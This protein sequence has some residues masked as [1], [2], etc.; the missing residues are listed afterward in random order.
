[1]NQ[2]D[3]T[4][5]PNIF[6]GLVA[7]AGT[8]LEPVKNQIKGQFAVAGYDYD[9]I[10]VSKLMSHFANVDTMGLNQYTR[11][12][13]LMNLGDKIRRTAADGSAVIWLVL[14]ELNEKLTNPRTNNP[15]VFVI[16]S[17][18]NPAEIQ[19]LDNVFSRNYYT[20]GVYSPTNDR[21]ERLANLIAASLNEKVRSEHF[22]QAEEI[23]VNDEGRKPEKL[24]QN[25]LNTFPRGDFFIENN[26]DT[27]TKQVQ[28]FVE[29]LFGHPYITPTKDESCM[30]LA[31]TAS[32]ASCD[33][34]RQVGAAIVDE[35]GCTI[36]TGC[37]EV[38]LPG[39]GYYIEGAGMEMDNRDWKKGTDPNQAEILSA[40]TDFVKIL[41]ANKMMKVNDI[42]RELKI[43]TSDLNP[44]KL[45]YELLRGKWKEKFEE[46]RIRNLIE[47]GRVVHAEMHAICEAARLG[48]EIQ[49]S[50]LYCT[51]FPCHMCARHIIAAGVKEVIYIEPYPKSLTKHLYKEEVCIEGETPAT[52]SSVVFRPF[53]G[54]SPVIY[55][56]FFNFRDRKNSDG[57]LIDW[58]IKTAKPS[59]AVNGVADE[60]YL[61]HYLTQIDKVD[62]RSIS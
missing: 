15:T 22:T 9:E 38:P 18:K 53:I 26:H 52:D 45:A 21:K 49:N 44:E 11:I 13:T 36:S 40:V 35:R 7:A 37:N 20:I 12:I 23:M 31:R 39:G 1:M 59:R 16:E 29:L 14:K 19:A 30:H 43:K 17:L 55:R 62:P 51:T 54:V 48:R 5:R 33:L 50:S 61:K 42:A 25:L 24:S 8:D 10:K 58:D 60:E 27:L 2:T 28:R 3:L 57:R 56:R 34:S 46:S 41:T 4:K 47:F 32:L 6:L